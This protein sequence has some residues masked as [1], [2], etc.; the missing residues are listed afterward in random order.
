MN[1]D[2]I[3]I[4]E[5]EKLLKLARSRLQSRSI[6]LPQVTPVSR[7]GRL[8]VS[9]AQQRLWFLE[10]LGGLGSTYHISKRL[11]LRGELDA[12][13]LERALNTLVARHEPLRTTFAEVD[14]EPEQRIAPA[15]ASRFALREHD[16]R[17]RSDRDAELHR[18]VA[19]EA[20][21]PFD[22]ARGPLIRG[23][24]VRLAA[25][26][27]LL[28]LT[29]HHIVSDGW[30]MEVLERE[31][32]VLYE[33]YRAGGSDPLPPLPVQYADYAAW[34]RRWVT[35]ELLERQAAY[36]RET[37]AGAPELLELPTDRPRP[38]RAD[39]A[40]DSVPIALEPELTAALTALSRRH[41]TTLFHVVLA[42]W[43]AVLSRLSGQTDVVIGTPT[44][45]RNR[46]EIEGLI[47]FF[48]NTLA[49]RIDLTGRPTVTELLRR[50]K[51]RALTAQD[52][53]DIPFEQVVELVQPARSLA[54]SP[55]FQVML[56]WQNAPRSQRELAGSRPGGTAEAPG[57]VQRSASSDAANDLGTGTAKFDLLLS[58]GERRGQVRGSLE[59][60]TALFNR[61]TVE[62]HVGYL[63]RVLEAMAADEARPVA[64]LAMLSVSQRRQ[65]LEEW[66][67]TDAPDPQEECVHERVERQVARAPDAVAVV[68]GDGQLT[69]GELNRRA[70]RLAHHLRELGVG[71]DARVALCLERGPELVVGLLAVLKAGGAYVPLD[72]AYPAERLRFMLED[73]APVALLT[74]RE[75]RHLAPADGAALRVLDLG[76]AALWQGRPEVDADP[77]AVGLTPRHLAY[78]IYTS[79]STG[80]PKGVL[81]EHRQAARLFA[82]TEGWFGFGP[83]DV[84][85]LFHSVA[86]DFSVWELWGALRY[87]GR[88]V[89][90]GRDTARAP[91]E[92]YELLCRTGVTV[93][94]QTPS[95]FRQLVGAQGPQ[96]AQGGHALR[97]VIFGGE[98]LDVAALRPWLARH[99]D[100]HPRLVNMYGITETTVHVTYRPLEAADAERAGPS[101]IGRPIPD[102]RAYVLDGEGEPAPVGV[103]GELY[104][105]GAG[106]ARGYLNRPGLTAERFVPDPYGAPGGRLYRSGD[107]AR[108]RAD[109]EL[110]YLGRND[111]QVKV[112]GFR[113]E[114]GEIEAA[115]AAHPAVRDAVVLARLESVGD[116]AGDARLVAYYTAAAGGEPAEPGALRAHLVARLPE[117][118]VPAAYVRL[119]ALPLTPSGKLDRRA[120][121]APDTMAYATR[122]YEAPVG[123][124]EEAL[125]AIW[126]DVLGVE[127]VGRG[128]NFFELGGH[129]LRVV[130]VTSRV[131]Q[132]LGVEV[133]LGAVFERPV[134]AELAREVAAV[135][136]AGRSALPAIERVERGGRLPA[137]F[138][139][140]RLWFLERLGGLG[141][142]YHIPRRLRLRG[143]LDATAL[144][145]ALNTLV[146]RHEPLRTTFAEVDGEPEQ[147]IAPAETSRFAL[148]EY[149]LSGHDDDRDAVLSDLLAAEARA[150]FDLAR[151][152]LIRGQLVRLAADEHLLLLT[153]HHIVSDGWSMEVLERELRMLY[154]AYRMGGSDPLPPL[155]VQY[156]DYAAWQ[157]RWVTGE[158]LERQAAYWRETLAGAPE[159]LELPTDR[160]RPARADYA[161]DSVPIALEPELTAALTALSRRHGTTLFH[162]VLAGWAAVLSRLSGQMDV[163][164]GT[165][166]ANRNR[167]EIEGLIGFFVNTLALRVELTGDPTVGELLHRVQAR[168]LTAQDHQDIPFEQV[169]ELVQ[170]ARSLAHGPLFQVMLAWQAE[171]RNRV[172]LPDVE[173]LPVKGATREGTAKF[174]LL[175][176]LGE[177][178]GQVRGSLGFATALFDR[179][180][181]ERHVGYLRRMLEAMAADEARPVATLA[182]LPESERRQLLEEWNATDTPDP[183]EQC[184]HERVER[185][186]ARAPDAVAVVYGDGQLTYG[187][188]NRRANRLAHHLR[189]LGVGPD[190]RVA[191]CLE[192][193]PELVVGLLAVLKAGGA[194]V[195]LDPAYP[196]ERLRFML[197]DSAPVALLTQRELRH[198]APADGAALRVL[199]LGDAALWQGRPEVDADPAAV[200]LTPRHLAYVIYTSGSTGTPK[201]VLVEHRQAARLFAATEGWFGFGPADVWALFHSVAFDFSVWELWGA[202]RYGGRLVVVGRDTARAPGE[203]YEL[204]CRTGVTVLNQTPSAFRQLVDA[205]GA[206]GG[207]ALRVVIFG[208][209]ALDVAALRPWLARHGDRHPRLVNMYGITETT[210]HVTYRPLEAADAERAGPSPIGRPIP[211]LRAYVLDGEGEPAPV[212]VAGELYVG[213]AGVARGYLNR[214]GLT[215]ERF[216][217]DPYGPPGGRL[218]RSGDLARRRADGELE[219]LGRNDF[220]VKVRGF[221]IELGE[222]EAALAAHPAVRDAVVLARLESVGDAAG[223]ARLVAYYTAAAGGEPAEPGAL[224]AHLVARLP[225]HMVPAAY[226]RL[227]ALPLTPSGKL[228]RRALPAPDTMAYATRAYEAPVG[229]VEEALAAIWSDVLGVEQVG[230]GDNF[231]ELG[232]HSL[233]AVQVT[234][235]VRQ[236]LGVEVPLGAV[237]ERPVLAELAREVAAV[238]RAGR[239]ALPAIERVERG[240]R[241]PASFAQRR[242]WF[243]ERLGGLGGAYHIPRRLRLRGALDAPALERALNTLVARHEPLRTTFAEVD[244]EP[245]QRIAP[246]ETS[247][248]ALREHDLSGHD[249]DRDAVLSD[250]LAAEA[251]APF[252]LARGPLIRGQLVRL[253]ADEHLLLLTMHH[254]VSDGWSMEVLERE[255]RVLYEAYRAGGSDPLPPLPVQY[256][257]YAAW[258]RRWVT[259]ELL[260]RQAAYWRETLAG[261]PELLE[262]PTDRPRPARADYAG[263]SVPITLEPELTAALTALSR[264]HGTTL[265]HVVLAGWAAVLS[266]LSGQTDVVI[267]TP[268]A[269]RNRE[270]IEGLIGFFVNTL[271]LRI[272]LTDRPTVTELL[273]R[274]KARA[275]TAQDHQDIP[276]EQVVELVQPV[277]SLAHSPL[278]QV[279]FVWQNTPVGGGPER[280]GLALGRAGGASRGAS[281][282]GAFGETAKFDISLGLRESGGRIVGSLTYATALFGRATVARH[283]GYLTRVLAQMV[284]DEGQRI[285]AL[286]LPSAEERELVVEAWNATAAEYP[287][288]RCVH[289]LFEMQ[290]E[291]TPDAAALTFEGETL[292]Y[293][294]LNRRAN[295]LAHHLRSLGVGPDVRV[296]LCLERSVEIAVGLLAVLKAGGA[297][298][299][300]DPGYPAERL[301]SMLQ[302][303]APVV[304]LSQRALAERFA[305]TGLPVLALDAAAPTWA[306]QPTTAPDRGAL[307]PAHLA[308]VI[309]T[310]GST[311]R[312]KGVM[313][314][315][316]NVVNR[317]SALHAS[318][319]LEAHESVLQNTSLNFDVSVHEFLWPLAVGARVVMTSS[320]AQKDPAC[321]VETI[322]RN[323]INRANLVP[324]M[325]QLL[326]EQPDTGRCVSLV[327]V[328][329][330]GEALRPAIVRRFHERLPGVEL[331]NVYG[332]SEAAS[333]V[334]GPM[335]RADESESNAPIGRPVANTRVYVLGADGEPVPLGVVGELCIGGAGLGRGYLGRPALTA[336]RFVADPFS[337]EAG[338]R[339]YRTGDL[340]RWRADGRLEFLGRNDFQVKVRGFRVELGEI[341]ARL[342]EHAGVREAVVV[343]LEDAP[344]EK[345]LVAYWV[346]RADVEVEGLR[347]HLSKALPAYMVPAAYVR[348][349]ALPQTPSGKVDRKALPAPDG[350]AYASRAYEAP[351]GEVEEALAA[352]WSDVLGVEQVGRWDHF[353]ELGGHS[354]RAVQVTSRVRQVLGVEVPLGAV[355]ERPVLAELAREV[356][357]AGQSALPPIERVD[358]GGGLPA[359]FAQRRLWFLE[360]LGGLG[361]AYHMPSR[362]RLSGALDREAL[363]RA[364]DTLVA[365]HESLRTT[366]VAVNGEPEQ[367]IAPAET[368]RFSL[369]EHD[370]REH[371]ERHLELRRLAAA[372]ANERF[373]LEHGPLIRGRLVRVADEEQVLLLTMHHIVSDAWSMDVLTR[374]LTALYAAY[375]AGEPNPLSPLTVQYADYAA[376]QR[377]WVD[378]E[379]LA[380]QAAYWRETLAGAP[381][382]LALPT[383]RPRPARADY[384]GESIP[385]TLDPELTKSLKALSRRHETTLFHVVLAAW[386]AV[387]SR[388]SGQD[389]VVIGTPTANRNREEIEGLIG[390]FVN[391]LALR[392]DLSGSPSVA[393]VLGRVKERALGAQQHQDIPF[394]QVVELVRPAR[395]L[396]HSPL[397]QV[398][399]AWQNA[400]DGGGLELEGLELGRVGSASP[401]ASQRGASDVTAKFD[402]SLGLRESGGRIVGSLTYAT[403]LF[404]RATVA[405]HVGYLTRVLAQMAADDGR[406]VE[407]LDL[408]PEAERAQVVEEWARTAAQHPA[409][410]CIHALFEAQ[411]ERTPDAV[412]VVFEGEQL[413]YAELNARANRLAHHLRGRGVGPEVAVGV[414]LEWRPELVAALLATLKAGGVYVP[415]DPALPAERLAYMAE[416]AGVRALVTRAALAERVPSGAIVL[417]DA[418]AEQV[419]AEGEDDPVVAGLCPADLAYVIYTSGSTGRPK[420]VAVEH[421]PAAAHLAATLRSLGITSEDRVLQFAS[422]SFDV[423]LE[424]VFFP[425]LAG[426]TLVLRGPEL[427]STTEFGARVRSLGITVANLPPAYWQEVAA[428]P[429][430]GDLA[431]VRLLL[432][433]GDA[434]PAAA[435]WAGSTTRLVNCYGPTEAVVTATAF[436]VGERRSGSPIVPIGRPL[437]G[438]AAYVLDA[439]GAPVPQGV[440]GEL[441][442]GGALLARGYLGRPDVTAERFVPDPFSGAG[443]RLYR[444]GDRVRWNAEGQLEF[445]GRA[446]FQVKVRGFRVELGEIEARLAEH[447]GVRDVVVVAREEVPGDRRLVAYYVGEDAVEA[448]VLRVHL[449]ERLPQYMVPA[450]YVRLEAFPLTPNGKVDRRALP[451]PEGDAYATR[452]YEAPHGEI[453]AALAGIWSELLGAERVGR[454]DHFFE[455]GGHSLLAVQVTSRVRQVL[456]MEAALG[457]VFLHPVLA[458]FAR[459]LEDAARVALP[460]IERVERGG[461]LPLSFAQQRLWF[462]DRMQGGGAAYHIPTRLRL[463]GELDRAALLR[464][465]DRIV[466]RHEALRTT[467]TE[468]GGV[469]AQRIVP[470]EESPFRLAE[471]DLGD[472]TDGWAELRRLAAEEAGTPFDLEAAPLI[473]G[474]LIRLAA[475]DHVLLLTMHHI[476]SDGWSMGVLTRELSALYAAFRSGEPDPL[477]PLTIQYADYAAWQRRWVDGQVLKQQADYWKAI[478]TGAP[479]LLEL[480]ADHPRPARPDFAGASIGL[481]LDEELTAALKALGRRHGTT[482]HMTL[483]AGWSVVL[484]RLSGQEDVVVGTPTANRGRSEIEG[485]IGF[486]VNTLA[487]RV[488]LSGSPSVAEVLGRVKER[489]LGAQQHQDIPF[490]QVV[491]LVRP[492]RSLSHSPL[493]QVMFTWQNAPGGGL[494]LP[495]LTAGSLGS[496]GSGSGSGVTAKFDLSLTL[497]E[498]AGKIVG[499]ATYATSIFEKATVERCLGYLQNVLEAMVTDDGQSVY[500]IPLMDA[501]ERRQVI[502]DGSDYMEISL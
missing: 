463:K 127:Q 62:R 162:V 251:R 497:S 187:E 17:G 387:L 134:L 481:E 24:L 221:R 122:A 151:G 354:L 429:G 76:D 78:V 489:A 406:R 249:D 259:G 300:L 100:R 51:A 233:R 167:E 290:V 271:A 161:G 107:L 268:T 4:A 110:E 414:C 10:R 1:A 465:L 502:D 225:E 195:P 103:A 104:V 386:A 131:R 140:R 153:M 148:R 341:E 185:Q 390:F 446:D 451:A 243:L 44:A 130:Q 331:G 318:R 192:R 407:E 315:H 269:N 247:R 118:M 136:R 194:Y 431:G 382:V 213:G 188:L 466:A 139:Q 168:A 474:R 116:A 211:D 345:R 302:D 355:F 115:L 435:A 160:P 367:R 184:V 496:L 395:S 362:P 487:L 317:I 232:G 329:S 235:R 209:E 183:Q 216:V 96:G 93:L 42:G 298:V 141:G 108:R 363:R 218:Y 418:D 319:K 277:R 30:S 240:G 257:D 422:A 266:R 252:D 388:L 16:L 227:D 135:A 306:A 274:V 486:F 287:R 244:G 137:S 224:R 46:P 67:A 501:E 201:G 294:E 332:P 359:S 174:D 430:G 326:L 189:E 208:G 29:M 432:V 85:A 295:R 181:V 212:G 327:R 38:A 281:Q 273:R 455:L 421:G 476:V 402:V 254:I 170:P 343:A 112:R 58:L 360:Q 41:G 384:A 494:D 34:Q 175:L 114:L 40:G 54:N 12:A 70:N 420:G 18:I 21:A 36:W 123:E 236:A 330:A 491:E 278:F 49:L 389:D 308:Y 239:S 350:A 217:P 200:G 43:A 456:G 83:A 324:S 443:G 260:E 439:F 191:L 226:V 344:G 370:L 347:T 152:P 255:L 325:L 246:A 377:Q 292:S 197:E 416:D 427:W 383:D 378:G 145:R 459:G 263:D 311:G 193:G 400:P 284:A 434:L 500:R 353:F 461:R 87:G 467:F 90:V 126:S 77:A 177:R 333:A 490:E 102:L 485:L 94:N 492:A 35:G 33:A 25:D 119:D 404:G 412:A 13:A 60:A 280:E 394:E 454:W 186:V 417:V 23:Q 219:Y 346:G 483:L 452:A 338:A 448:E 166:T 262:L 293:G 339:L 86:F 203:F 63:R 411:V 450:A 283:V 276:F 138:A 27:H 366:F 101:P 69:Y 75:L 433:G 265:F 121:P 66:N 323:E 50:V 297:Y 48:V 2:P 405:R 228:D 204:L 464:A 22:L 179:A 279:L 470:A 288:E 68:Y 423:S 220:Q 442:L 296:A 245:E 230:R 222:I 468:N 310:S 368:S 337:G 356:A 61:A 234:S 372:E 426:A 238:A 55:V 428:G 5:Q 264:R 256:A 149:D 169:V 132:A 178:R 19:A 97:V 39:Y 336:E 348:L 365:R 150:P 484:S 436:E 307:T 215:A 26:E 229:E 357:R 328:L 206:P 482:L 299:P 499:A 291:R 207:H 202:L 82:A 473:R 334:C 142:A 419:C 398:M 472:H 342:M 477:P 397:F 445:L 447:V 258:Q 45:N 129:S 374:E 64:T 449:S 371:P 270:E 385:I 415:L 475:E 20:R 282:R 98:A 275:L 285:E 438:R 305:G 176:S 89:V 241:L 358:R 425:L 453:E 248:F 163:V 74:Q 267:G 171:G 125:A 314:A 47:G 364:L 309:Y 413:T 322:R 321:L 80:T 159:L 375:R 335:S 198:L 242:L 158:L 117:H 401:G 376:W 352:I 9:F 440:V 479:E 128:D 190:A 157:R 182:M 73:S 172:E 301:E 304:V 457:E 196:A 8:P 180:T 471:H 498:R 408:L 313:I 210:V 361:S 458:D 53:Q 478:L 199:D 71:P 303:S 105:G 84:W 164:I 7:D 392:L 92:F 272:D 154:E 351:V 231:F 424:Q 380:G 57:R 65:L 120:L 393:E 91:G 14:G 286:R 379:V 31:L 165:P 369:V 316:R 399:F 391:T 11:R 403:A 320:E 95:A 237:F 81:V 289:E 396:A 6:R 469:P 143:A 205:P 15:E 173:P 261:A 493:F 113:I 441:C 111:F 373:D 253:A 155:P 223:D 214:P 146:A 79:G 381:D 460:A 495:G 37:L 437:P 72:P 340:V 88:L 28:L 32:R 99:G 488:D 56:A 444:T 409:D 312:P 133:P 480:P 144:E 59:F 156:A 109:G 410:N 124:V 250:L 106:L 147:R 3:T 462:L 349:D 52:H